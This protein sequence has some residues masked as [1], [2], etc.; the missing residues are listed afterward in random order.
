MTGYPTAGQQSGDRRRVN[1]RDI[2]DLTD[3]DEHTVDQRR[4]AFGGQQTAVLAGQPD[5]ERSV[6]VDQIDHVAV[7]LPDEH[8]AYDGHRLGRRDP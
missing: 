8:H 1:G 6:V 3:V 2:A 7:H 5:G 4:L